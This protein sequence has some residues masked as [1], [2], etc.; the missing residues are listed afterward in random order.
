MKAQSVVSTARSDRN[1][2]FTDAYASTYPAITNV[3]SGTSYGV[4]NIYTG[5]MVVPPAASVSYGVP[6]DNTTGTSAIN[7]N[8][9]WNYSVS[10]ISTSGSIGERLKTAATV[11]VMGQLIS[12][13]FSAK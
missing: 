7:V 3:R 12:D 13:S 2:Y 6:V 8:D 4:G 11:N 10:G 9:I 1:M 5:T